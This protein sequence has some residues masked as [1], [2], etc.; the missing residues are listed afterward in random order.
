M[1]IFGG[2]VDGI[3]GS[4]FGQNI[5]TNEDYLNQTSNKD[6]SKIHDDLKILFELYKIDPRRS[7]YCQCDEKN[8]PL[9]HFSK[10]E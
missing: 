10:T 7:I 5:V 3:F 9:L 8:C 4:I 2:I 1:S 6:E